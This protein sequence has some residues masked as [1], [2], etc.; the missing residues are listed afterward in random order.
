[1]QIVSLASCLPIWMPFISCCCL[2][3]VAR[4]S[5]T[6]LNKSGESACSYLVPDHRGKALSFSPLR[7]ILAVGFF[8]CGLYDVE[9]CSLYPYFFEGFYQG[10]RLYFVKCFSASIERI[11]YMVLILSFV[12]VVHHVD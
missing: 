10:W 8:V 3:A 6:M 7:M 5:S 9:V 12:N 1:M 11:V 4:T 2:I